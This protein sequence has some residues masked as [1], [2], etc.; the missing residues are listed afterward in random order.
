MGC[1]RPLPIGL[2]GESALSSRLET[3]G[4]KLLDDTTVRVLASAPPLRLIAL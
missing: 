3:P 2:G 4:W 1:V